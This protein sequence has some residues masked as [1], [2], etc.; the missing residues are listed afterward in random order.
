M[1]KVLR[2]LLLGAM[3]VLASLALSAHPN[4]GDEDPISKEQASLLAGR[5]VALLVE[6]KHL[7]PSWQTKKL[8]DVATIDSPSG[9]VWIISFENSNEPDKAKRLVY[10]YLDEFG[11]YMGGNHIGKR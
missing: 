2:Q 6:Q 9:P 4:H 1:M 5:A 10:I 3:L 7:A 11:N 8:K